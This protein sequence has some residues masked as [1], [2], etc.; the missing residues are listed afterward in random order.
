MGVRLIV[1]RAGSGK[2]ALCAREI[3]EEMGRDP[4][5]AALLWIMP[6]Q[7]TFAGE[8]MLLS[9]G[10]NSLKAGLRAGA[11]RGTFRAQVL[12]FRRLAMILGRELGL[13]PGGDGR[14]VPKPMDELARQVLLEEV[15]RREKGKLKVFGS[16][17]ERAGFITHLDAMMRELRQ[18]GHSGAS[19]RKV[20]EE[21]SAGGLDAVTRLKMMDLAHLLE[22]WAVEMEK[23]GSWDFEQIMHA[24]A[25]RMGESAL[26]AGGGGG[27]RVWVDA[28]SAMTALEIRML[29]G[30]GLHAREVTI[31][32][33]ADP[34]SAGLRDM[35]GGEEGG[36]FARTE[37]L[38]RRLLDEFRRHG[39]RVEGTTGLRE[40]RRFLAEGVRAVEGELWGDSSNVRDEGT[41]GQGDKGAGGHGGKMISSSP[42][43]LFSLSPGPE[44][45]GDG[46]LKAG[47][48]T[49]GLRT[50][51]ELWESSEPE[52]EVRMVAQAIRAM[53]LGLPLN[54]AASEPLR[55]RQMAVIVPDLGT[56]GEGGYED[57]IRRIFAEH[58]IPHFID[59]RRSMA[60]HPLVE[61]VRAAVG[62]VTSGFERDEMLLLL[63]TGLAEV[64]AAEVSLLENYLW[65][66]GITRVPWDQEWTWI[67]PNQR[68]EDG[69]GT[70][71][72][73]VRLGEVNRVRARVWESLRVFVRAMADVGGPGDKRA[74]GQGDEFVR[75]LRGFLQAL[76]IEATIGGWVA[77]A[78]KNGD[79]ELA[80][81]HEQARRGVD[82]MLVLLETILAGRER[83]LLEFEKLLGSALEQLTLGLI[84]PTVDQVLV[85]SVTRSRV[86]EMEAVFVLG[87]VEGAFPKVVEED[88]ILSDGQ[89]A[90]FNAVALDPIGEGSDRQLL[91]MPFFD[92]VAL[93][94]SR[95]R[96]VVSY[97]VADRAGRALV[98]SRHVARLKGLLGAGLLRRSF[99]AASRAEVERMST[100]EDVM[101]G[102][103]AWGRGVIAGQ[104]DKETRRQGEGCGDEAMKYVYDWVVRS[105]DKFIE[106]RRGMLLRGLR[107]AEV[108]HLGA[109]AVE[110]F[111]PAG[112]A[113]RMSVSQLERFAACPMQYFFHY[114][115]G[116]APREELVLDS[117][118]LGSL[119][120]NILE[121]LYK[122]IIGGEFDWPRGDAAR[123]AAALVEE[124]DRA[125]GELHA[126]LSQSTPGY[127]KTRRR[128]IR[129]LGLCV[130]SDRQRAK[131]GSMRPAS[132]E[133]YFG[134][135]TTPQREGARLVSLPVLAL[136]TP[137]GRQ[138]QLTGKIDR[139]DQSEDKKLAV[140]F[141]YKSGSGRRA[142]L[143]RIHHGLSVQLPVYA[144]VAQLV[145][146]W[147]PVAA[148]YVNLKQKRK[149]VE[150]PQEPAVD[151]A[152]FY[153]R[154]PP[155]GFASAAGVSA[156]DGHLEAAADGASGSGKSRWYSLTFNSTGGEI[157]KRGDLLSSDDFAALLRYTAWK[158][159]TLAD[160][161]AAGE[162]SP[163][164]YKD[165]Q[166]IACDR[167]DFRGMCP[168]DAAQGTYSVTQHHKKEEVLRR[169]R[170][171]S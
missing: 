112:R 136:A 1:G 169:M 141:D 119:Q 49:T 29:A 51:V 37:R 27:A 149:P 156:L 13:F 164:P 134:R 83:T 31:T 70:E 159:G 101:A 162:I 40:R 47:L 171:R 53:A 38:Y 54:G 64:S 20:L 24:A 147:Q 63:K 58:G 7:G 111:F 151:E 52:T 87:A 12:S 67:A 155:R 21:G 128:I 110:R 39:V 74:G 98:P 139:V 45:P 91:E 81:V 115:L 79:G 150:G 36:L 78:R 77:D 102:V 89:R 146:R 59:Q 5:G 118:G 140:L 46:R 157:A 143:N 69:E 131:A 56:A 73:R 11:G 14:G 135:G 44:L 106:E 124:T 92:Y 103:A 18:Q 26:I 42:L 23:A 168:F 109:A 137:A 88:P 96:L 61:L 154:N 93:T 170:E 10:G 107:P 71:S 19:L 95:R 121:G 16:S 99:D 34:D 125:I 72:A 160:R 130:E 142:D 8:R 158:I 127:D 161:L 133:L 132:V 129:A 4:L 123:V 2:T 6:E 9:G 28:F 166:E 86:P 90:A 30:L 122:R 55:Y 33:L 32:L 35:R 145:A 80:Q 116:L 105:G 163:F 3:C 100:V 167:C 62:I 85:S 152:A 113:L 15:V 48:Q 17:A 104:G 117:L 148:F 22:A 66:H 138:L 57:A 76:G 94:R 165:G 84:P 75:A 144:L 25:G 50:G 126:E 41:G 153:Q 108:P 60:H 82:E 65:G 43:P 120:H 68:E 97:P 114:Q